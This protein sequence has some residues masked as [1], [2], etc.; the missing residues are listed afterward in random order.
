MQIVWI[1]F[2]WSCFELGNLGHVVF[3][4][5]TITKQ[6][7]KIPQG[8]L[9]CVRSSLLLSFFESRSFAFAILNVTVSDILMDAS[10]C[11]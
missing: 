4:V 7:A 8:S 3:V 11:V 10:A 9:Q 5:N 1:P 2:G 6:I